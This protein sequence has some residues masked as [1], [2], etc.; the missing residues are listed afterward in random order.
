MSAMRPS[1]ETN[2]N[3]FLS[4][5]APVMNVLLWIL[6]I[7]LAF[8]YFAGGFYKLTKADLLASQ[9]PA[10]RRGGWRALGVVEVLGAILLTVPAAARWMPSLTTL[11]AAVLTCHIALVNP[12]SAPQ[13]KPDLA[14]AKLQS[15]DYSVD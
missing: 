8:T 4:K 14:T 5:E 13:L 1:R 10:V 11:G 12:T 9:V 3:F 15:S 7:A 6:Q 2:R